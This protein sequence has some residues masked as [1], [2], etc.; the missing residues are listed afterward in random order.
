METSLNPKNTLKTVADVKREAINKIRSE[1]TGLQLG[2]KTSYPS[3]NIAFGKYIRFG[4]VTAIAGASGHGKSF[5]LNQLI[6]SFTSNSINGNCAYKYIIPFHSFEM[7]PEDDAIRTLSSDIGKSYFNL[8]SSEYNPITKT[9]NRI[10]EEEIAEIENFLFNPAIVDP[11]LYYF[12][13]PC[14]VNDIVKNVKLSKEFYQDKYKTLDVPKALIPIDHTLLVE[15]DASEA[16]IIDTFTALGKASIGLKKQ[17]DAVIFLGQLNNNIESTERIRNKDMHYPMKSDIYAQAQ[18]FN[19]CDNV[20][21]L[22][23]PELMNIPFY[24]HYAIPS[25]NLVHLQF[26]KC[27]F[28]SVGSIWLKN[29]LYRGLFTENYEVNKF[30]KAKI[31]SVN[32]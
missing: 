27:R 24:G 2:L 15:Q 30:I 16:T 5:F 19:A 26:I 3:V 21:T 18:L 28:G 12:D 7:L 4:T 14:T 17:G 13:T 9:Y 23:R 1:S 8:L 25:A 29:E 22:H 6:K 31:Q 32:N 20:L 11:D 10:T